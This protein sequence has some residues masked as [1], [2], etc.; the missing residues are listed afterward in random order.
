MIHID[1]KIAHHVDAVLAAGFTVYSLPNETGSNRS[2]GFVAV[3]LAEDGPFAHIQVPT[4]NWDPVSLDVPIKPSR[5]Y[6]SGVLVDHDGTPED[7]VRALT[8]ACTEPMVTVRF[9]KRKR[10]DHS[11]APVVPN[12]GRQCIERWPGA[13]E[14]VKLGKRG[15]NWDSRT[16]AMRLDVGDRF[17]ADLGGGR[18]FGPLT[19]TGRRYNREIVILTVAELEDQVEILENTFVTLAGAA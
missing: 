13:I 1:P 4:H 8:A 16:L 3:C 2:A 7:A 17:V 15:T 9:M 19:V 5:E 14:F 12:H 18:T 11:P 6:G 10:G